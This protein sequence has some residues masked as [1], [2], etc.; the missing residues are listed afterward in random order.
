MNLMNAVLQVQLDAGH[1]IAGFTR[2]I[3]DLSRLYCQNFLIVTFAS[4]AQISIQF[5]HLL[6]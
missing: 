2:K 4:E 3:T 1:L 5:K 6:A